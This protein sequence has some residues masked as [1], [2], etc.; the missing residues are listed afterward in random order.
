MEVKGKILALV[1]S[2]GGVGKTHLA[3]SLSAAL[4]K[5]NSRV[6]LIDADLGNGIVSDRLGLYPKYNLVHFF[7]KEKVLE[8][9][10]EETPYGFFLIG[11]E[12][13]NFSL[14]NVNYLQKM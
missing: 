12:R 14:A 13:G 9:L 6:L 5:R 11:G 10:I 3:A 7:S 1:S 8:H 4:A 2:K